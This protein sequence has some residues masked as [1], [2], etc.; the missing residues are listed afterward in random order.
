MARL[1]A[2]VA[3]WVKS[4]LAGHADDRHLRE[5][6]TS[7]G[8]ILAGAAGSGVGGKPKRSLTESRFRVRIRKLS[9]I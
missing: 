4:A 5:R 9:P 7:N 6:R 1:L 8:A 3:R 2:G